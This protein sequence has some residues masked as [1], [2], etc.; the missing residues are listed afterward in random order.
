MPIQQIVLHPT[1]NNTLKFA[2]TTVGR[3]KVYKAVQNFS[4]F[5]AWYLKRQGYD[6]ESIQRFSNL[7]STIGLTRKIMRFGK[8]IEHLQ[9]AT[10]ALNEVEEFAKFTTIGRQLGY[11]IYLFWDT[12]VWVHNAGV[13]KFQQIKRI[14]EN[15]NRF[16]LIGLVFSVI[17]GLYKLHKNGYQYN[18]MRRAS[19]SRFAESSEQPN[20]KSETASLM[21]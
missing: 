15:A 14:N 20:V 6:K 7:K 16:W 10:K 4:R 3:D 17:H 13:Y 21:K 5:L 12:F 2:S 18:F 1:V 8:P 19:K 11:A 9:H